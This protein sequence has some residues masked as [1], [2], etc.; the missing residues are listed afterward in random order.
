MIGLRNEL[1][2][3][4][5]RD[6]SI[7]IRHNLFGIKQFKQAMTVMFY[8]SF[9]NEVQTPLMVRQALHEGKRVGVPVV[10]NNTKQLLISEL[11]DL[12]NELRPGS[13]G[14]LE[15]KPQFVR[16]MEL[17]QIELVIL[18]GVAF[19]ELG[20]RLGYGGGYYDKLLEQADNQLLFGLAYESQV[21]SALPTL[22]HDVKVNMLV[23]EQRLIHCS[24][25]K[26]KS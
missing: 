25:Y 2:P 10:C 23:T 13:F 19:D 22:P 14:I 3:Q 26:F 18:P 1:S 11:H 17:S 8:L 20:H 12:D 9:R 5:L 21:V 7:L 16:P 24:D 15:P 6:K 4:E